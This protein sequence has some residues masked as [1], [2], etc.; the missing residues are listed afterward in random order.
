MAVCRCLYDYHVSTRIIVDLVYSSCSQLPDVVGVECV[1]DS[2]PVY[3]HVCHLF[4]Y[5]Q[6]T[7]VCDS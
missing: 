3:S 2:G 7:I 5:L 4:S 1:V 6:C